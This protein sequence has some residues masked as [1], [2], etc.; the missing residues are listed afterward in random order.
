ELEALGGRF[1]K[2]YA[3]YRFKKDDE[4]KVRDLIDGYVKKD[5]LALID[6]IR[7]PFALRLGKTLVKGNTPFT[8]TSITKHESGDDFKLILEGGNPEIFLYKSNTTAK[9]L[10]QTMDIS[11]SNWE[12]LEAL[13]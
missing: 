1:I 8:I 9:D 5:Q 2:K 12:E 13:Y 3:G 10:E 4:P 11:I 7:V 6:K